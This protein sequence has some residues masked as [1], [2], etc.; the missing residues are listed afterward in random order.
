MKSKS[1]IYNTLIYSFTSFLLA[2]IFIT[3][4]SIPTLYSQ[5]Q[6]QNTSMTDSN[7]TEQQTQLFKQEKYIPKMFVKITSHKNTDEVETGVLTIE[8]ISSD[9]ATIDCIVQVDLN[10]QRPYQTVTP[11]GKGGSDDY[12]T[13]TF[14]YT[15]KYHLI[16]EGVNELTAKLSCD[17]GPFNVTKYDSVNVDDIPVEQ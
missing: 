7:I 11:T 13:W 3:L 5:E 6:D 17:I 4:I 2:I 1:I 9:N 12:S 15:S 16:N 10:N 14:T 8:G